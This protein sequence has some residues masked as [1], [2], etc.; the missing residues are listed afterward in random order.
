MGRLYKVNIRVNGEEPVLSGEE[1]KLYEVNLGGSVMSLRSS[2]DQETVDMLV[3]IVDDKINQSLNQGQNV[4]FQNAL[5]LAALNLAEDRL[6]LRKAA[7]D[8]LNQLES[9]ARRIL[10]DLESSPV[11][12]IQLDN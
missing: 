6:M 9:H 10:S 7:E 4:S 2:H 11:S 8:D 5:L 12:S 1:K 3:K